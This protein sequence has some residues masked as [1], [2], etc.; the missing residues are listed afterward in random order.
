MLIQLNFYIKFTVDDIG[1]NN[2]LIYLILSTA[3]VTE[4]KFL[5]FIISLFYCKHVQY[6]YTV[7]CR[8]THTQKNICTVCIKS[9]CANIINQRCLEI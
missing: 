3:S 7:H 1:E 4:E 6:S 9:M 8:L 2:V 5:F